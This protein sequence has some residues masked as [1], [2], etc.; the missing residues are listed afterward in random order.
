VLGSKM[1]SGSASPVLRMAQE[2]ALCHHEHWDG[3]GYPA[4]LAGNEIPESARIVAIVDVYDALTHDR[5]YRPALPE[6]EA[7]KMMAD[8]RG[9]QF[10][11]RL[12]DIFLSLLPEMRAVAAS[13]PDDAQEEEI[14]IS[15][16]TEITLPGVT[17]QS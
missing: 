6:A 13:L 1:L 5:V 9:K 15:P 17:V 4:G 14:T 2:I 11:P 10:E 7:L 8:A 12:F 3:R 16:T